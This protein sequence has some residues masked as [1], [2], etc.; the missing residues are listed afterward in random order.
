MNR[1]RARRFGSS[2]RG[3]RR[4]CVG[5]RQF[6]AGSPKNRKGARRASETPTYIDKQINDI[7]EDICEGNWPYPSADASCDYFTM[8]NEW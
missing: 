4:G 8:A 3:G 2:C 1:K 6:G 7:F 5:H